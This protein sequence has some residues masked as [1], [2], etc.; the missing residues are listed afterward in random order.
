MGTHVSCKNCGIDFEIK[1]SRILESGNCCSVKCRS[2]IEKKEYKPNIQCWA[3][4]KEFYIALHHIKKRKNSERLCCSIKCAAIEKSDRMSGK[5]NHQ[6]GLKGDSNGSFKNDIVITNYG[7]IRCNCYSHPLSDI[8]G[9]VLFHRLV[10]EEYLRDS[11]QFEFLVNIKEQLVL[12]RDIV[13]HH[14]D[15]N[16]LNNTINN[17]EA[18]PLGEHSS[19]HINKIID[20]KVRDV[21][22][23]FAKEG[24]KKSG[25][26]SKRIRLD[27]GQDVHSCENILILSKSSAIIHT[28]L[29]IEIPEGCVGLLWSKS[30]LSVKYNL[31]VGAGC[32]DSGYTGE[33]LVHLY[34]HGT[35]DFLVKKDMK[36]VQLLTIPLNLNNYQDVV[37]FSDSIRGE[38][39]FGSQ[40]DY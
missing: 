37:E 30:G 9:M 25:H 21:L 2:V 19:I 12:P 10:Y 16:I 31:E 35:E 26:L 27:A 22:G 8:N 17:L 29:K 13:V 38:N 11:C 33:I 20:I 15:G 24:K 1:Q 4:K 28:N 14:K 34:N 18:M 36:I 32:I 7:Y 5:G 23:R 39:G 6:Y 40:G 3:C